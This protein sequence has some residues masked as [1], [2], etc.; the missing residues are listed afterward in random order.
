[1][2]D[3]DTVDCS[4]DSQTT[5]WDVFALL[6]S[7]MV[8]NYQPQLV[9]RVSAINSMGEHLW[10]TFALQQRIHF[11]SRIQN[12]LENRT[13][14]RWMTLMWSAS[15]I[16]PQR[17]S[18]AQK[19]NNNSARYAEWPSGMCFYCQLSWVK[20]LMRGARASA[21][22]LFVGDEVQVSPIHW[23]LLDG[24]LWLVYNQGSPKK[25][26]IL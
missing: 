24:N 1:M 3:V 26:M 5:T 10:N 12:S 14:D 17:K 13:Y 7:L 22:T 2:V 9:G 25:L 21:V 19:N 8:I 20:D 15:N 6:T 11:F 18:A 23:K 16:C 4:D